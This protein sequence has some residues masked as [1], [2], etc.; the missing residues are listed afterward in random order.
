MERKKKIVEQKYGNKIP[1]FLKQIKYEEEIFGQNSTDDHEIDNWKC[2]RIFLYNFKQFCKCIEK[3][4]CE[5]ENLFDN[6]KGYAIASEWEDFS[7]FR[8]KW[9]DVCPQ[10][11]QSKNYYEKTMYGIKDI[12]GVRDFKTAQSI[13]NFIFITFNRNNEKIQIGTN[14]TIRLSATK[15]FQ[16]NNAKYIKNLIKYLKINRKDLELYLTNKQEVIGGDLMCLPILRQISAK[17]AKLL[18]NI[19]SS[20]GTS[21]I[22]SN[23]VR[24]G[25]EIIEEILSANGFAEYNNKE[26]YNQ[27]N[28]IC[29]LC[30]KKKKYH[31][32]LVCTFAQATYF[33]FTGSGE[34]HD[35]NVK[36]DI[37]NIFNDKAN[38]NGKNIKC[39]LGSSVLSEGISLKNVRHVHIT[40]SSINI[41]QTKQAIGRAVRLCSHETQSTEKEPQQVVNIYRYCATTSNKQI[42]DELDIYKFTE[43]K[44]EI[45]D[46]IS[47][48]IKISSIDCPLQYNMN[49]LTKPCI[50]KKLNEYYFKDKKYIKPNKKKVDFDTYNSNMSSVYIDMV[51]NIISHMYSK[52][53]IVYSEE[54]IIKHVKS[55]NTL[56]E[57]NHIYKA[58]S[59]L[60]FSESKDNDYFITNKWGVIGVLLKIEDYYIFQDMNNEQNV[61]TSLYYRHAPPEIIYPTI[62]IKDFIE[63]EEEATEDLNEFSHLSEINEGEVVGI[64][65]YDKNKN[66]IFRIR[67]K[68]IISDK[69]R[70]KGLSNFIG[71]RCKDKKIPELIELG[72]IIGLNL[73]K[74]MG[75]VVICNTLRE[76]LEE[77]DKKS[78]K[79]SYIIRPKK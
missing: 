37:L 76:T 73:K 67:K 21:F 78:K 23:L 12:H 72:N 77:L 52:D 41:A 71:A 16:K 19:L 36:R 34:V 33:S 54:Y 13:M 7:K 38:V 32:G 58:I 29:A 25:I 44:S 17:F 49:S 57:N 20:E 68:L 4:N 14:E 60:T 79:K 26:M 5:K 39:L 55:K 62:E 48:V 53:T 6:Q 45:I 18:E 27:P 8:I 70:E 64:I 15:D 1:A 43:K 59:E 50:S 56:F 24:V 75:R 30:N 11:F 28:S 22:Y 47:D 69:K 63:I 10:I 74:S 35:A 3:D 65:T 51:K 9:K 42:P 2:Q 66:E 40:D 31:T 61:G 46:N